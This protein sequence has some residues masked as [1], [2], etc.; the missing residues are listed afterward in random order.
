LRIA[1]VVK[2]V[3]IVVVDVEVVGVIPVVGPVLRPRIK[4][5]ER[6]PAVLE[7]RISQI[8]HWLRANAEVVLAAEIQ[9]KGVLRDVVTAVASTLR[10]TPV[11]GGPAL[12]AILLPRI[13]P[14]PSA[15]LL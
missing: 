2:V 15:P 10:P 6:I 11:V 12:G 14:L 13:V 9:I 7:T 1:A 8:H 3:A 5:Q 4:Q